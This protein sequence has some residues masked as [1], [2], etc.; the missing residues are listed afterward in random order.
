[1]AGAG[2][3]PKAV[4]EMLPQVPQWS[5]WDIQDWLM[6]LHDQRENGGH[7]WRCRGGRTG[8]YSSFGSSKDTSILSHPLHAGLTPNHALGPF[9]V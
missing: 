1:M 8:E 9:H 3:A 5:T 2:A 4:G 7:C 6:R